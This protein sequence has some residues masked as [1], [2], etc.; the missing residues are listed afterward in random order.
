M[1]RCTVFCDGERARL[2][3]AAALD[4]EL[5]NR[6]GRSLLDDVELPHDALDTLEHLL[7]AELAKARAIFEI[8]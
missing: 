1:A 3:L 6:G 4:A 8:A 5:N 7:R 2:D